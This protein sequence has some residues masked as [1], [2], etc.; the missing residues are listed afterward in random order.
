[1]YA[2]VDIAGQQF[3]VEKNNKIFVHRLE[4]AEGAEIDFN[5]VLLIEDDDEKIEVGTPVVDGARVVAKV[6]AHAK[7]DK[8]LVF[9][10][11]RRKGFK[12]LNGHRQYF[13]QLLIEDI[14]QNGAEHVKAEAEPK[15][16]E[17][18]AK[19][20][21]EEAAVKVKK[22]AAKKTTAKKATKK[23]E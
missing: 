17:V 8:V 15:A 10:K 14:L 13:T 19:P 22:P 3:K 21:V 18:K 23:E 2:I 1:M 6:L 9:K 7:G 12:K 20:E 4:A 11:I 5:Q 16:E